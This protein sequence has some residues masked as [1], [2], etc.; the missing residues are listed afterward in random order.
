MHL[1][2]AAESLNCAFHFTATHKS[3]VPNTLSS[4]P[5]DRVFFL[6]LIHS[7]QARK[8]GRHEEWSTQ[9]REHRYNFRR[10]ASSAVRS[11]SD[12]NGR[13]TLTP[14]VVRIGGIGLPGTFTRAR[15]K[16]A[17]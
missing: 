14:S 16:N 10:Y 8:A 11:A 5:F 12:V 15:L 6:S 17:A 2:L 1:K 3:V 13:S 9:R 4:R 7:E